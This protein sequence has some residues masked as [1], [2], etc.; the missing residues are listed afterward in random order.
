MWTSSQILEAFGR[1]IART[2]SL[3][4]M[5]PVPPAA[6]RRHEQPRQEGRS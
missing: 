1:A 5:V 4:W 2:P 6:Y 3:Y